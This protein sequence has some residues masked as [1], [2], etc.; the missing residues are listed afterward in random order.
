[1]EVVAGASLKKTEAIKEWL[2][3]FTVETIDSKIAEAAA[4]IRRTKRIRLPDAIIWATAQVGSML[5]I[6]RNTKD[7]PENEA[8]IC[9]PY[10]L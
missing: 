9:V 4:D 8:D 3:E 5:L 1:M 2:A 6:S 7:F 10:Q